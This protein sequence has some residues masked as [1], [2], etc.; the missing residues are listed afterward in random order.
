[1]D[2]WLPSDEEIERLFH[3]LPQARRNKLVECEVKESVQ[4]GGGYLATNVL[5]AIGL[6]RAT[7][8]IHR[9]QSDDASAAT[10]D[11]SNVNVTQCTVFDNWGGR[12]KPSKNAGVRFKATFEWFSLGQGVAIRGGRGG[13]HFA[14][15]DVALLDTVELE[16]KLA[17]L[18]KGRQMARPWSRTDADDHRGQAYEEYA[19]M[20]LAISRDNPTLRFGPVML[21]RG[22]ERYP[23]H[24][25]AAVNAEAI[26]AQTGVK[27][28]LFDASGF[29]IDYE[30]FDRD[31]PGGKPLAAA[32]S[33][34]HARGSNRAS[35]R[36]F[37]TFVLPSNACS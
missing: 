16:A 34:L 31:L 13:N 10:L 14:F 9:H 27:I 32:N 6:N 11:L 8:I 35:D 23:L 5:K 15:G 18:A 3:K 4:H 33:I 28:S 12:N 17:S 19:A 2:D 37:R 20:L 25:F 36:H 21:G 24:V 1:M 22:R 26:E 30:N 29:R 7:N